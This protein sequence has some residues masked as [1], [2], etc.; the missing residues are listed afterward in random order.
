MSPAPNT[1][2]IVLASLLLATLTA[3]G[4][5]SGGSGGNPTLPTGG[6]APDAV[7]PTTVG[8]F[9]AEK[10]G[11]LVGGLKPTGL[12]L[13][14]TPDCSANPQAG[15]KQT[16][17][18]GLRVGQKFTEV[19]TMAFSD[20][21]TT[22]TTDSQVVEVGARLSLDQLIRDIVIDP[23]PAQAIPKAV[24]MT[25]T[26]VDRGVGSAP[27][28][29]QNY[30]DETVPYS[31]TEPLVCFATARDYTKI[32]GTAAIGTYTLPSGKTVRATHESSQTP[33]KI[34][35]RRGS[36]EEQVMGSGV[37]LKTMILTNDVVT[38]RAQVC[39]LGTML[40]SYSALVLENGKVVAAD[41]FEILAAPTR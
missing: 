41:K 12:S 7:K 22:M 6:N 3:C 33:V 34:S 16:F 14:P 13:P 18:S 26:C 20:T 35:C 32:S 10:E 5:G 21:S 31:T 24:R 1:S 4:G 19:S 30:V 17:D 29:E 2:K 25:E 28:C 8:S 36:G 40:H 23:T 11:V 27:D 39:Y 37:E 9:K 15:P 38:R